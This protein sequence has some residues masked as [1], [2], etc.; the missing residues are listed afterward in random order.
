M[1]E[2]SAMSHV[3]KDSMPHSELCMSEDWRGHRKVYVRVG[4]RWKI[5]YHIYTLEQWEQLYHQFRDELS[6][7]GELIPLLRTVMGCPIC[8]E[9]SGNDSGMGQVVCDHVTKGIEQ[10]YI[11]DEFGDIVSRVTFDL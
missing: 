8:G 2:P 11:R 3:T 9:F 10:A 1:E 4:D 5:L 6:D 7:A